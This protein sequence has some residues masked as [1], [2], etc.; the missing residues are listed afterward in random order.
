MRK[1]LSS[2]KFKN[3]SLLF[4]LVFHLI[5]YSQSDFREGFVIKNNNDT[6][7]GYIDYNA[8]CFENCKFK[9]SVDSKAINYS[10]SEIKEFRFKNSKYFVSKDIEVETKYNVNLRITNPHQEGVKNDPY[11]YVEEFDKASDNGTMNDSLVKI[12]VFLDFLLK[13]AFDLYYYKDFNSISH[14]FIDN[15]TGKLVMLTSEDVDIYSSSGLAL[16]Y[17]KKNQTYKGQLKYLMQDYPQIYNEIQ[18]TSFHHKDMVK[19]TKSYHNMTCDDN[20]CI[21]FEEN[22]LTKFKWGIYTGADIAVL[23]NINNENIEEQRFVCDPNIAIGISLLI[24]NYIPEIERLSFRLTVDYQEW[25]AELD[26]KASDITSI[27]PSLVIRFS[28]HS[29]NPGFKALYNLTANDTKVNPFIG[30][31][32]SGTYFF[33]TEYVFGPFYSSETRITHRPIQIGPNI[34]LGCNIPVLKSNTITIEMQ[35]EHSVQ[36][37]KSGAAVGFIF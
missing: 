6:L 25:D 16:Y 4:F 22:L 32:I 5:S 37:F 28:A 15:K 29:L 26:K 24:K 23:N 35:H 31:G 27:N 19:L 8:N 30:L 10:A 36:Y 2:T 34:S 20:S 14:Y 12:T 11:T 18:N 1:Y 21:V 13:G 9:S 17:T 7:F 3:I 33:G